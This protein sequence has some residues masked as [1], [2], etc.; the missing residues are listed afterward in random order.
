MKELFNLLEQGV[1]A[2]HAVSYLKK[3]LL[4]DGFCELSLQDVWKLEANGKYYIN[5]Y[6]TICMA[7][8]VGSVK[9]AMPACGARHLG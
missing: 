6:D 3:D 7:F 8:K 4:G 5:L 9:G 1:S 2:S